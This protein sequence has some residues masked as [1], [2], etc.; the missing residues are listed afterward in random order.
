MEN[1]KIIIIDSSDG[2]VHVFQYDE[3]AFES[4]QDFYDTINDECGYN[5]KESQCD[6]MIVD[7]LNIQIH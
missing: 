6:C 7:D 4:Y 2:T 5:F 3:N 1:K